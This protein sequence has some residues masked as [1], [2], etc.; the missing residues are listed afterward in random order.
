M[1]M[2]SKQSLLILALVAILALTGGQCVFIATSGNDSCDSSDIDSCDSKN[3]NNSGLAV[4]INDGQLI[5]APVQGVRYESGS[6][7]GVTGAMGEF[8]YEEGKTIRFFI[9][10]I[11]L[12]DAGEG[13]AVISPLD[14]VPN[15]TIDTP[16]VINIARLLQ[17]LDAVPGDNL[18]TIPAGLRTVAVRSNVAVSASIQYLDFADETAFVNAATQLISALTASYP[19]TA[20]LVDAKS[21]QKHLAE[22]LGEAGISTGQ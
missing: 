7:S 9:G 12:G 15:G 14:L 13:K 4:V 21:A 20:V 11:G 1:F 2:I 19:F 3:N 16:A 22:S 17:S 8:Q 6:V 5:D 10:D 18:I